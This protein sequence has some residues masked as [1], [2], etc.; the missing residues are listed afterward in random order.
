M[1]TTLFLYLRKIRNSVRS[2]L[3]DNVIFNFMQ[4]INMTRGN[5]APGRLHNVTPAGAAT[6]TLSNPQSIE[7]QKF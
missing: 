1:W 5:S 2:F 7:L 4:N 6:D 3:S